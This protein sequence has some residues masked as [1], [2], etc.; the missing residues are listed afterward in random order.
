MDT[1]MYAML[2]VPL[3]FPVVPWLFCRRFGRREIWLSTAVM[4]TIL[5]CLPL[6]FWEACGLYNCGQ[7][8]VALLMLVPIW[9][10]VGLATVWPPRHSL[11]II[12]AG[13]T[14]NA[15]KRNAN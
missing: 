11:T 4:V 7:G 8:A 5:L 14:N 13:G 3:G 1:L 6:I 9:M 12:C 15:A 2:F 10:F